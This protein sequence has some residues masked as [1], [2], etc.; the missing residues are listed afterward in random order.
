MITR[1]YY[2]GEIVDE[3]AAISAQVKMRNSLGLTGLTIYAENFVKEIL[4][5]LLKTNLTNLNADR[6]N[7]PGLDLG[8]E[9]AGWGIQVTTKSSSMAPNV[10]E[11]EAVYH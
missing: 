10:Q 6:S 9:S 11:A 8:D 1:G 5:V 3:F 4:N 7:E 2:I